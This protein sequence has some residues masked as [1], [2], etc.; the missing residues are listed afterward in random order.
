[1]HP[2]T[3]KKYI[4]HRIKPATVKLESPD[5]SIDFDFCESL[6]ASSDSRKM[7]HHGDCPLTDN[8][9]L[10]IKSHGQ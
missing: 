8:I 3:Q 6:N 7:A 9:K 2:V 5:A 1:M 10:L 4:G